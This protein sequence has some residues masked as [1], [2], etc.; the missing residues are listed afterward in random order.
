MERKKITV[1]AFTVHIYAIA[2]VILLLLLGVLG[3]KY[4]HLKLSVD[5]YTASTI[6]M[7]SQEKP[8]GQISDYGLIIGQTALDIPVTNLQN[9]VVNLSKRLN[10]DIVIVDKSQKILADTIPLNVGLVYGYDKNNQVKLAMEDGQ[11]KSFE[12]KGK[13]YQ[14]GIMRLVVPMKNA[15]G[16]ITGAVIISSSTVK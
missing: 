14:N 3:A 2:I 1:H 5:K 13:D 8:N 12:E 6:W 16:Q 4:A 15:S 7:N 10:R 9:Y 11:I